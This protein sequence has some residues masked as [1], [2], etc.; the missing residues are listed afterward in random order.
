GRPRRRLPGTREALLIAWTAPARG[1]GRRVGLPA[2]AAR[3]RGR[4]GPGTV[5]DL[6]ARAVQP[7]HVVPAIGDRQ[8]VGDSGRAVSELDPGGAVLA[9]LRGHAVDDVGIQVVR[10]EVALAVV[11]ADRPE[12][13]DRH[14]A[15]VELVDRAAVVL[16]REHVQVD[17]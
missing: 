7:H 2:S 3:L 1:K 16:L 12:G 9:L 15:D 10:L 6:A 11:D 8:A 5:E 17:R 13:I 4:E 14:L